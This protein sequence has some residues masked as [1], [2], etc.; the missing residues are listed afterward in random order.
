MKG[1]L[2]L[3]T[4]ASG[5]IGAACARDLA[6][7]G[8]NLA[9][10]YSKHKDG[11]DALIEELFGT[12]SRSQ[13]RVSSHRIDMA[14]AEQI[15]NL[16]VEIQ[17][18]HGQ[19]PDI[20]ISNAGHG[21]R[22]PNI[23]DISLEEWDYTITV[24]LRASFLLVKGCVPNMRNERWGRIILMSSIAAIGGGVNGCHYA[25][26]KAGLEGMGKNLARRLASDGITVNCVAPAMIG[27]TRMIPNAEYVAGTPGDVKNIPVGRL[28]TPGEVAQVV[29]MFVVTGYATGQTCL[30]SGGLL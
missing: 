4:G 3:I 14:S 6:R 21:K 5:G 12:Y 30:L 23:T 27:E 8:I 1:K 11:V 15:T 7:Y 28:G 22:I 29:S 26:S 25:A 18:Q 17:E 10:T 19:P 9:L 16:F 13:I 20:L 2:A 24:N